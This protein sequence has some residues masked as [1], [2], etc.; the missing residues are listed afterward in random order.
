LADVAD[1]AG[2]SMATASKAL[3]DRGGVAP[4]TRARVQDAALRLSF[5]HNLLARSLSTG[6]TG[7]VGLLTSD[8]EGRFSLPILMGAED[9]LGAEDSA[10]LLSD[11]RGDRLREK[12]HI[13]ALT[14]RV[15]ALMVVGSYTDERRSLSSD[16]RLQSF[17]SP[18]D[19]P[20]GAQK[21]ALSM[22]VIYVYTPSDDPAD[23]SLTVDNV[24]GGRQV[25]RHL[26]VIGRRRILHVTG[27]HDEAAARDRAQGID[28]VLATSDTG[29]CLVQRSDYGEW[30]GRWGRSATQ[31]ALRNGVDFDAVI[32]DSDQIARGALDAL[33]GAGKR[34]PADVALIGYDNW[35]PIAADSSPPISS[36]EMN[37]EALGR[38][39]AELLIAAIAGEPLPSGRHLLPVRLVVRE[40]TLA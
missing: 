35:E 21:S 17:A 20:D 27:P 14:P 11:A 39:A 26:V 36:V 1:L 25:A 29:A 4:A 15:D 2:V 33:L 13:R 19:A 32:A 16:M 5:E 38:R 34:V 23:C 9:G 7:A 40:S 18:T 12:R 6:R 10:V 28:E 22:P 37:L 24:D 3:N 8:L 31:L 30:S